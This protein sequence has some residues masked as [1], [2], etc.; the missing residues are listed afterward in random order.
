MPDIEN[1]D[2]QLLAEIRE[3]VRSERLSHNSA[4]R[5]DSLRDMDISFVEEQE[6]GVKV[7][8]VYGTTT[9]L[10]YSATRDSGNYYDPPEWDEEEVEANVNIRVYVEQDGSMSTEVIDVLLEDEDPWQTRE[11]E[12]VDHQIDLSREGY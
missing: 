11:D 9:A 12:Y 6:D 1:K 5:V 7:Y 2:E 10:I 8:D 3:A 4:A